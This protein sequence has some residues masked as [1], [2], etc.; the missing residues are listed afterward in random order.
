MYE[1][2]RDIRKAVLAGRV[3]SFYYTHLYPSVVSFPLAFSPAA[4]FSFSR[5]SVARVRS[6]RRNNDEITM[7][8]KLEKINYED[9]TASGKRRL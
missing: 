2:I 9:A 1:G 4:S 5:R 8:R 3:S 7:N 6:N